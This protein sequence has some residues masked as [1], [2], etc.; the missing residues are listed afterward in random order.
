[1]VP[2]YLVVATNRSKYTKRLI[3]SLYAVEPH[4]LEVR[5]LLMFQ[6]D[7]R[8]ILGSCFD[9]CNEAIDII[10]D[11]AWIQLASDEDII[12]PS[13]WRRT[14]ELMK[15]NPD[16]KGF[17]F[18]SRYKDRVFHARNENMEPCKV[19]GNQFIIK[20]EII[21]K[22]RHDYNSYGDNSDGAFIKK[23]YDLNP[24]KFL[25]IDEVLVYYDYSK[26]AE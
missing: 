17:V 14:T 9:K 18:S 4:G 25:F 8:H 2:L 5:L 19:G 7:P 16:K 21:G 10:P 15:Q 13:L 1:M 24:D 12:L 3:D 11:H 26:W 22:T 6:S 20:R 23:V